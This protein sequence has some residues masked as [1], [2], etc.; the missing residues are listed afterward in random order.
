M[1]S[2]VSDVFVSYASAD[3]VV[4]N[5]LVDALEQH[6]LNCWIAPRDVVP[7]TLYADGI[8]RAIA[9]TKVFVLVLSGRAAAS[10]HVGKE[11]ERASSKGRPIIA[12][13]IDAAP[14]SPS[15][16]YF[17]SES[18]WIDVGATSLDAAAAK[19]VVAIRRQSSA[20]SSSRVVIGPEPPRARRGSVAQRRIWLAVP[21]VA[22]VAAALIW[23]LADKLT[24]DPSAEELSAT[25]AEVVLAETIPERSIAVLPFADMSEKQDQAHLADGM[26]AEI[27]NLLAQVP[28][29]HVPARTSSFYFKD[30]P[31]TIPDIASR[32]GV[33]LVLEGSVRLIGN[34]LRVTA[35]LV[36]AENGYHLWS[37]R[38]DRDL[39]DVFAVQDEIA[40]S[41]VQA[42]Q[43]KLMGG[44]LRR[45][46]GGTQ[47]LEAYQLYLRAVSATYQNTLSSLDEAG[48]YLDQ[49]IR[50]D[51]SY[52]IAWA[53]LSNVTIG[54][55][56]NSSTTQAVAGYERARQ[57]ALHALELSPD[58]ADAHGALTYI[59]RSLDWDWAAAEASGRRALDVDPTNPDALQ[60]AALLSVT[61]GRWEDAEQKLRLA[62]A[63]DPLNSYVLW[64]LGMT[65][66]GDRRFAEA[67][68]T[69]RKLLGAAPGNLEARWSLGRTLLA[70]GKAEAALA[71][72]QQES[73]EGYHLIF[74]PVVL[75]GAGLEDEAMEALKT[76]I[77]AW[78]HIGAYPVARSYAYFGQHD[79]AL[80]WLERAYEQ[81]DIGLLLI[82]GEPIFDPLLHDPRYKAVLRKANLPTID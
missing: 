40:D 23:L 73:N 82:A 44:E 45:H 30:R 46:R 48:K 39:K 1:A 55:T 74:L 78:E 62:L 15:F 25:E 33:T 17:L 72:V 3:A 56:D 65:L 38:Y 69:F 67:E 41:V 26:A 63:R 34:R 10:T 28:D 12:V 61:L 52:G 18:Q 32:L 43:I 13:R 79:L 50:I 51:P 16:E 29:L 4:A 47:N 21:L 80:Q 60:T 49:A 35:Q 37:Q 9:A 8:V 59:Y 22:A 24:T 71:M 68:E 64:T 2:S 42:L 70:Q 14:L 66:H 77:G 27:I 75:R 58:I 7:G 5:A 20:D 57:Q 53:W 76:Q 54:K 81:R 19:L 31:T 36:R 6:G 11:L